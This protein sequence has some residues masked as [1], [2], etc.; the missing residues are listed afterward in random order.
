[1]GQPLRPP[2]RL[3]VEVEAEAHSQQVEQTP[4]LFN[5]MYKEDHHVADNQGLNLCQPQGW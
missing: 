5:L 2:L 3:K 1:M 4:Q